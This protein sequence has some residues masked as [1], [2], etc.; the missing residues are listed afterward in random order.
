MT[1]LVTERLV[2]RNFA[3]SDAEVLHALINQYEASA[4]AAYDQ[5]W[6]T[7]LA[8][9]IGITE[10]FARGE[11]HL[12][13]ALKTTSQFIG[14]IAVNPAPDEGTQVFNLGYIF[15][16]DFHHK[17]YATEACQAVLDHAFGRLAAQHVICGTAAENRPSCRL[18][19]R[20]GFHKTAEA[21]AAFQSTADGMPIEFLGCT[22]ALSRMEWAS[23]NAHT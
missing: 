16:A 22:Y 23:K 8:E 12:A 10:W 19:E 3:A 14:F 20:L 4:Y 15:D 17:G 9:I 2:I 11:N 7:S 5:P 21:T 1:T 18:L 13:V 6:P